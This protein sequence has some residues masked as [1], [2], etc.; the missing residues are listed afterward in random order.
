VPIPAPAKWYLSILAC[1]I[2]LSISFDFTQKE[3]EKKVSVR[4]N[5]VGYISI[6][7]AINMW[8]TCSFGYYV[9]CCYERPYAE[10]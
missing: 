10:K 9:L 1:F 3:K 7:L 6:V 4:S 2:L 8:I 5:T